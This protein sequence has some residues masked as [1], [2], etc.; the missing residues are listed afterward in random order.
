MSAIK[1]S[2]TFSHFVTGTS[3]LIDHKFPSTANRWYASVLI[4][5]CT[6]GVSNMGVCNRYHPKLIFVPFS[7]FLASS[8]W[9]SSSMFCLLNGL[10]SCVEFQPPDALR[11]FLMSR[12][13]ISAWKSARFYALGRIKST[14][15]LFRFVMRTTSLLW[16]YILIEWICRS[17]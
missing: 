13:E 2:I 3:F 5:M 16:S 17:R 7:A 1:F 6:Y 8:Y 11:W 10:R 14:E 12:W 15:Q 4:G 9:K